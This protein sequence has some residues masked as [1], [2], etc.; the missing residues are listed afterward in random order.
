KFSSGH[1]REKKCL[2]LEKEKYDYMKALSDLSGVDIKSHQNDP[3]TLVR[4]VR[5]WFIETA[6]LRKLKS[7][8]GIWYEFNDFMS[9]FYVKRQ[10]EGF[11]DDD[12]AIMPVPEFISFIK[13]W[14]QQNGES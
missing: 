9:D 4:E 11:S 14:L 13:D 1:L 2:I 10:G 7:P 12:L 6:G 3:S 5:N 8:T